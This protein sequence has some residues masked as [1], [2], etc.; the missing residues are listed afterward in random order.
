MSSDLPDTFIE[1]VDSLLILST[2]FRVILKM[3]TIFEIGHI[4]AI[5]KHAS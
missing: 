1:I 3:S 4:E 5:L 2:D